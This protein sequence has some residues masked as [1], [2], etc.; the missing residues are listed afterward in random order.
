MKHTRERERE[1]ERTEESQV[2]HKKGKLGF[3]GRG[4]KE[5]FVHVNESLDNRARQE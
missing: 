5:K 4:E 2:K 3:D 1:R